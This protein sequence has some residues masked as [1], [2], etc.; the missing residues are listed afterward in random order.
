LAVDGKTGHLFVAFSTLA[1]VLD[2]GRD[3]TILSMVDTGDGVDDINYAPATHLLYVAAARAAKLTIAH[4][5]DNGHL[6][7]VAQV[8]PTKALATV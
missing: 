3:G 6:A 2:A 8:P 7:I 4:A 1:E 5:D